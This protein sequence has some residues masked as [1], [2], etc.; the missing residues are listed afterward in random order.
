MTDLDSIFEPL[1]E[2][3]PDG[4]EQPQPEQVPPFDAPAPLLGCL[5]CHT[6]GTISQTQGRKFLGFGSGLPT[7]TCSSCGSTALFDPGPNFALDGWRIKYRHV[8]KA[9]RF[10][11]VMIYLGKAGW[12]T[13]DEALEA[14]RVGYIQRQR[15]VQV[16]HNDLAW[17]KPKPLDPPPP[18][19]SPD[20]LVYL[21]M[22]PVTLQQASRGNSVVSRGEESV[23][24]SGRFY[25]T[26]RKLHLLGHRRDWSHKLMDIQR[27]EHNENYW[28]I[29][30]GDNQQHY[31]GANLP[32]QMDAQLFSTIVKVLWKEETEPLDPTNP[33]PLTG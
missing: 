13:A 9:S 16:Q 32:D 23:M 2:T 12:L 19:M 7:L 28:R 1:H 25:V 30:V 18:L 10:Y 4:N 31:Q 6:E 15:M 27:V 17:L 29:Y 21:T 5:Y 14:S 8:N 33:Q 3:E 26:D 11:Y 20:E 24:D 22:N